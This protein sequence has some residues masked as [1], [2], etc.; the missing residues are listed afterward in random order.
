MKTKKVEEILLPYEE[1]IPLNPSV[2]ISD[3][4]VH[5]VELMVEN[6]L[7]HIAVVR[8]RRPIGIVRFEDAL[9]KLGLQIPPKREMN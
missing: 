1:G 8:N 2:T 4:I 5:A 6:N 3:K 7:K 9:Q